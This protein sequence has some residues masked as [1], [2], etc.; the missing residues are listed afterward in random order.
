MFHPGWR[1]QALG[2]LDKAFDLVVIGGGITGC[3]VFFDAAQ[4]GLRVLLVEQGDIASGTSS[5]SSKLLHGGLRYLRNLQFQVTRESCR[6]RDL[7]IEL[8]PHLVTPLSWLYPTYVGDRPSGK[9]VALGLWIYD[10][11]TRNAEKFRRL[12]REEME[13]FAPGSRQE[14]LDQAFLYRDAR[15]DD[16]RLTTA[17]AATGFAYGGRVLTYARVEDGRRGAD[18]NLRGVVLRDLLT[19]KTHEVDAP[20]IVNATGPWTDKVRHALGI[21]GVRVRPSRGSH[22]IFDRTKVPVEGAMT[23]ASPDDGRPVFFIPHPEGVLVGTTDLFHSGDLLDPRPT[24]DEVGYMLRTLAVAFPQA[25]PR[26]EDIRGA[27]AGVRPVLDSGTDD[28]SKASREEAVWFEQGLLS[29]AGGKLTT[30][31]ATAEEVVDK[32]LKRL[33]AEVSRRASPCATAGT[34]LAGLA[35]VDLDERLAK[36]HDLEPS[37]AGPMARRLG[38]LAWTAC[39]RAEAHDLRP[40]REDLD[41]SRAELRAHLSFGA[42]ATLS[43]LLLRRVRL[44]MWRPDLARSLAPQLADL[45]SAEMDTDFEAELERF[46]SEVVAWS[47]D[48]VEARGVE[49]LGTAP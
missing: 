24:E 35:P 14:D 17:V 3:G 15:V 16:A 47:L 29:V 31:R 40:V 18:G 28:P 21:D 10:R 27:F 49:A 44:G 7:Q 20:L 33:P 23:M 48:G 45:W 22:L 42:V 37:L 6:E 25:P 39:H 9:K 30:W 34:P 41:V 38:S 13:S 5:R 36:S 4:R 2:S 26:R 1:A 43:D 32:A 19:G 46:E 8:N 12:S 11:L